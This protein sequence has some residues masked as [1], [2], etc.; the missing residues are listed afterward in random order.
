[1]AVVLMVVVARV[2]GLPYP[3]GDV[4]RFALVISFWNGLLIVP[5]RKVMRWV[6]RA[7]D[8]D[9]IER[10]RMVLS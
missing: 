5:A 7:S 4:I 8:D 2:L 6:V 1:V 3:M 9:R 10:Y